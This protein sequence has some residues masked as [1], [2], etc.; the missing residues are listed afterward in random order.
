MI[1]IPDEDF[2][3][4]VGTSHTYGDCRSEPNEKGR[5]QLDDRYTTLI[6]KEL[7]MKVLALGYP[8]IDNLGLLQVVNE[9]LKLKVFTKNCKMFILEPRVGSMMVRFHKDTDTQEFVDS[10]KDDSWY[11]TSKANTFDGWQNPN[12][13][14]T[15]LERIV[16]LESDPNVKGGGIVMKDIPLSIIEYR[17]A[18]E[19]A[20]LATAFNDLQIIQTI[21]NLVNVPFSWLMMDPPSTSL[22]KGERWDNMELVKR[23][24]GEW[25]DIF[26]DLLGGDNV[27]NLVDTVREEY[28]CKHCSH[29]NE[30][31]N[32]LIAEVFTPYIKRKI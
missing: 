7:G 24:Y 30:K 4:F 11:N 23:I 26:D 21:K 6:G 32:A 2:I 14:E 9:L 13:Q 1:V 22:I 19:S 25:L 8:G 16:S 5:L 27:R 15:V 31:G 10:L 3:L 20:S 18:F 28:Y 12:T 29:F 17:L